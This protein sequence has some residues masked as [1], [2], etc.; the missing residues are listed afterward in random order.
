MV[1]LLRA[2]DVWKQQASG[3]IIRYRYFENLSNGHFCVQNADFYRMPVTPDHLTQLDM[4][5]IELILEEPPCSRN[6]SYSSIT[7]A[8]EAHDRLFV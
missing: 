8:I 4:Q 2:F 6:Q 1:D 3:E 7:E 5:Y